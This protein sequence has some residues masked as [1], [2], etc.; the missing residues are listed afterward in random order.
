MTSKSL[1]L[2][3]RRGDEKDVKAAPLELKFEDEVGQTI[4]RRDVQRSL[5]GIPVGGCKLAA[6][7]P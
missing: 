6:V 4:A 1:L 2:R 7:S 5:G 3:V